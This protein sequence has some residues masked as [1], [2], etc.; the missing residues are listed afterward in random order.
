MDSFDRLNLSNDKNLIDFNLQQ[1]RDLQKRLACTLKGISNHYQFLTSS[2]QERKQEHNNFQDNYN[3]LGLLLPQPI[4]LQRRITIDNNKKPLMSHGF[5]G[6]KK[7]SSQE[8]QQPF[9]N[10]VVNHQY[11]PSSSESDRSSVKSITTINSSSRLSN[12][13]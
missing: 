5:L 8:S 9:L 11:N 4:D 7:L 2:S 10:R 13:H 12:H 6:A 1:S 3:N